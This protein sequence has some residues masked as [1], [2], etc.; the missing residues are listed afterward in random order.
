MVTSDPVVSLYVI[1]VYEDPEHNAQITDVKIVFL[2][3][4]AGINL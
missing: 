1:D 4:Y 3:M 2:E